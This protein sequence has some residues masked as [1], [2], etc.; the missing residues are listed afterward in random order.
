MPNYLVEDLKKLRQETSLSIVECK[1]ILEEAGGDYKKALE[2]LSQA[3]IDRATKAKAV[4]DRNLEIDRGI[5]EKRRD[6][7]QEIEEKLRDKMSSETIVKTSTAVSD[8]ESEVEN[9]K[10][11]V[12]AIKKAHNDLLAALE[13]AAKAA[14]GRTTTTFTNFSMGEF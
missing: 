4:A 10:R 11:E 2:L 8:L 5:T 14:P 13:K 12:I 7:E 1:K 9:L 6:R 3:E